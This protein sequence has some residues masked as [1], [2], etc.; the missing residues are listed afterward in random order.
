[1]KDQNMQKEKRAHRFGVLDAVIIL[2]VVCLIAGIYFRSNV[3][4][5]ITNQRNIGDYTVTFAVDD[6][7]YTTPNYINVGDKVVFS[8]NGET[9]GTIIEESDGN[10][11]IALS[12]TPSSELFTDNGQIIE[13][14]YPNNESRVDVKGRLRCRGTYSNEGGFLVNGSTYLS[15]GQ[16]VQVRTEWVTLDLRI[17]QIDA[18]E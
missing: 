4:E 5:W 16:T 15:A 10:S 6:I 8:S 2:L 13:V 12:V 7:R 18:V 17:L 11:R 9:F 3:I 1:M 14:F